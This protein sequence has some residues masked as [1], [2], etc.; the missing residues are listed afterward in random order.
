[1]Q[2]TQRQIS[3]IEIAKKKGA[4]APLY[5]KIRILKALSMSILR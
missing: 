5:E 2:Q 1:M 4:K 3:T